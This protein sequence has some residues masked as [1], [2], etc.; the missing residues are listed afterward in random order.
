MYRD[1]EQ[2]QGCLLSFFFS[3]SSFWSLDESPLSFKNSS[4]SSDPS[5]VCELKKYSNRLNYLK[6]I[7]KKTYF[8]KHFDL[9][10]GNI[11][12]TWKLIISYETIIVS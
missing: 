5:K 1:R 7:S 10:K 3:F 9:C 4:M 2:Q 6:N 11:K 12:A 8:C